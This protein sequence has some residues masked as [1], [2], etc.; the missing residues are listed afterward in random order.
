MHRSPLPPRKYSWY[1]FM[2]EAESNL[3][4]YCCRK[5][6]V[7]EKFQWH[8]EESN[9]AAHCLNQLRHHIPQ[10]ESAVTILIHVLLSSWFWWDAV[11][12]CVVLV[13]EFGDD[14]P[15]KCNL[16]SL[17]PVANSSNVS[18]LLYE[19]AWQLNRINQTWIKIARWK[20][21][22]EFHACTV[23]LKGPKRPMWPGI[24]YIYIYIYESHTGSFPNAVTEFDQGMNCT[25]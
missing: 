22:G 15:L 6:Y 19:Q 13:L 10:N 2:L 12:C 3:G 24:I 11:S 14:V 5:D 4:P 20:S 18:L 9:V 7:N 25:D 1:S 17:R 21:L 23:F 16:R 8:R